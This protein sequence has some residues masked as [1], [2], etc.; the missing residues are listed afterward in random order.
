MAR[1]AVPTGRFSR[2]LNAGQISL[3]RLG[4]TWCFEYNLAASDAVI[5]TA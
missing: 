4:R 2:F 1:R 3:C 5:L